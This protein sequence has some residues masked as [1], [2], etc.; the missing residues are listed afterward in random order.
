MRT[1]IQ[2]VPC[3][4][5]CLSVFTHNAHDIILA[6]YL[7]LT[8][9]S[10]LL[11]E[12]CEGRVQS[13]IRNVPRILQSL[14]THLYT[15]C[16]LYL[17]QMCVCVYCSPI[18]AGITCVNKARLRLYL[19]GSLIWRPYKNGSTSKMRNMKLH[20]S[21]LLYLCESTANLLCKLSIYP[22]TKSI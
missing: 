13:G 15:S 3:V 12:G 2:G 21:T 6:R 18:S 5:E 16:S 10:D 9:G 11:C 4:W 20:S 14:Y 19:S 17:S 7:A 8:M 1:E 22:A